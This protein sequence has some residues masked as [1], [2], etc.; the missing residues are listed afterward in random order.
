MSIVC[1][2]GLEE[3]LIRAI[4]AQV[5]APLEILHKSGRLYRDLK[6]KNIML[7]E[8]G[9]VQ[10]QTFT[11]PSIL[12][13]KAPMYRDSLYWVAPEILPNMDNKSASPAADIW[14]LGVTILE[15]ALGQPPLASQDLTP[16]QILSSIA[17]GPAP[18][19]SSEQKTKFSKAFLDVIGSLRSSPLKCFILPSPIV[20]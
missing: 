16:Q 13:E 9:E 6:A 1:P 3:T 8:S 2:G 4:C 14:A 12:Q 10:L 18:G 5:L 15:L 20:F 17:E 7:L 11:L 19:L